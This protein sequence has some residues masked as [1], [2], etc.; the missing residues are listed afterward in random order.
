[1]GLCC[2]QTEQSPGGSLLTKLYYFIFQ[3]LL[4]GEVKTL[5]WEILKDLNAHG[6]RDIN[7]P[8][9]LRKSNLMQV[10][11]ESRQSKPQASQGALS[12][13]SRVSISGRSVCNLGQ[14]VS[15]VWFDTRLPLTAEVE[16]LKPQGAE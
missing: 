13:I 16:F 9:S 2:V 6:G 10:G 3:N 8:M 4:L 12:N 15:K 7:D 1:M 14:L 5:L 11:R